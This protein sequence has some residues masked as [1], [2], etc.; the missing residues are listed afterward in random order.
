MLTERWE[1]LKLL[2]HDW[3]VDQEGFVT[4]SN[5]G[6]GRLPD[7]ALDEQYIFVKGEGAHP[8]S[9]GK[10]LAQAEELDCLAKVLD[11]SVRLLLALLKSLL[12]PVNPDHGDLLHDARLDIGVV[13]G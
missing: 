8:E 6:A 2:R 5:Q 13:A 10:P 3:A 4:T 11:L 12:V 7:S 1:K 9:S